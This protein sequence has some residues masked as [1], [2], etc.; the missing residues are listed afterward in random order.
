MTP[1]GDD[2]REETPPPAAVEAAAL[3][4]AVSERDDLFVVLDAGLR[5]VLFNDAYARAFRRRYGVD[6]AAGAPFGEHMPAGER[7]EVLAA[8]RRALAGE[9]VEE[10]LTVEPEGARTYETVWTPLRLA[11]GSI[12]GVVVRARD[13]TERRA[14]ERESA[15]AGE[16]L[17]FLSEVRDR[18]EEIGGTGGWEFRLPSWKAVWSPG[19]FHLWDWDPADFDGELGGDFRRVIDARVHPD[20]LPG[21]AARMT[22]VLEGGEFAPVDFR[23]VHRDGSVHVLRSV[24]TLEHDASGASVRFRGYQRDVTEQLAAEDA[25][26]ES[27]ARHV[28][29]L[30]GVSQ[31]VWEADADGVVVSDSPSWRACTGRSLDGWLGEAW[32][33]AIHPDDRERALQMWRESAATG[34]DFQQEHRLRMADGSYRWTSVRAV[35]LRDDHG[36]V[37]KWLGLNVDIH[38]RK[39]A[40]LER[41]VAFARLAASEEHF[42]SLF[43]AMTQGVVFQDA[44]G[45]ISDANRAAERI[46]GLSLAQLQGRDSGDPRWRAMREDGSDVPGEEHPAMVALRT[47]RRVEGVQMGVRHPGSDSARW[48]LIDAVPQFRQGAE[49]PHQV[50]TVFTDITEVKDAEAALAQSEDRYRY[51]FERSSVGIATGDLEGRLVR[52][53][54][55]FAHMLGYAPEELEGV[56]IARL[57]VPGEEQLVAGNQAALLAGEVGEVSYRRCYTARDGSL[58]WG[59]VAATLRRGPHDEPLYYFSTVVDVTA[60]VAAAAEVA[61]L[62]EWRDVAEEVARLGSWRW[63]LASGRVEWSPEMYVLH[64]LAPEDLRG[65][66]AVVLETRMPAEDRAAAR[67]AYDAY[68]AHQGPLDYEYRVVHRDGSVHVLHSTGTPQGDPESPAGVITGFTRDVTG[69]REAEQKLR[70]VETVRA[71]EDERQRLA[72]DLHDSVTQGLYSANLILG[73]LPGEL[74]RAPEEAAEDVQALRRLVRGSLGELRT[75]LYALRPETVVTAPLPMLLERLGDALAGLGATA[76]EVAV[77]QGLDLP[78]DVHVAFYR[79]AQEALNNAGKHARAGRVSATVELRDAVVRLVVTDDGVGF[80]AARAP[81]GMGL[82]IMRERARGIGA[83]VTVDSSPGAGTVVTLD[84]PVPGGAPG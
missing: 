71:A 74:E 72:R 43:D 59:D 37:R 35:P 15:A 82:A 81:E 67:S 65:D 33:G 7:E 48:I 66:F 27:D 84:W 45:A 25:L 63:D 8:P 78:D 73:V 68:L 79:I 22:A 54:S 80:D 62:Q 13:V 1:E 12:G 4:A 58:V 61:R 39:V 32:A 50:F 31:A 60:Q 47:G 38:A 24:G 17:R 52:V 3:L 57:A 36:A 41:E 53:N 42:R 30:E 55:A 21:L 9:R 18:A 23:V 6:V 40:E 64:D 49:E 10:D 51:L 77:Q 29:L 70:L 16:R 28:R 34:R 5:H 14:L 44:N 2:R 75:L 56:E 46:L 76:V 26:R 20:D 11:S 19:M 83:R 69:Q